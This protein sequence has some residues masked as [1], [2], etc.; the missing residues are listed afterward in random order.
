[1]QEST[2]LHGAIYVKKL[3]EE[4]RAQGYSEKQIFA[5]SDLSAKS[6]EDRR[7]TAPFAKVA[8]FMENAAKLTN[9]DILGL[10]QGIK[11]DFHLSGL[12]S[13]VGTASPTVLDALKNISR[14]RRVFSDAIELDV[15]TLPKMGD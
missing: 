3:A 15:E 5:G 8:A 6:I 9:N 13:Y 4:L 10:E 14:Y 11:R 7:P 1:M 2:P 12:I